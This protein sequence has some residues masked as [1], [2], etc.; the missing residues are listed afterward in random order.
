MTALEI[1]AWLPAAIWVYLLLFRGLFW[2][3]TVRLRSPGDLD[4]WPSVAV[5]VPARNEAEIIGETLP[6]LL[7]QKYPGR[8]EI[9]LV[10]DSS[11]DGTGQVASALTQPG[12]L[13]LHVAGGEERPV[14]W[15]GK[16]WA[17]RQGV[18]AATEEMDPEWFLFTDADIAHPPDSLASLVHAAVIDGRDLVSLMARLRTATL[19]ERLIVPAFVYFFSQLY[20]FRLIARSRSRT[21]GAAG[22]C[23]LLRA[24]ALRRAGGVEAI[25]G[26]VIDDVALGRAVKRS[27]GAT[28]LGYADRVASLRPY[29]RLG[30]LWDMVARS[31]YTQLWYSPL[32]LAGTVV[33]LCVIYLGP[34]AV[35]IAGLATGSGAVSAA[36]AVAWAIL[37]ASYVPM[38]RYYRINP[39]WAL[40][41]PLAA[42]LYGA[43]TVDSARRHYRGAGAAWKGRT[44]SSAGAR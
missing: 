12:G 32:A 24:E 20:P 42:G 39:L 9:F 7:A 36:G 33:G 16:T 23:V 19:W 43:M 3:P 31:A 40:A 34:A 2:L 1:V 38:V 30:D 10:D 29:P 11:D 15:V 5:V 14:G 13:P 8:A 26:A 44:Y 6:T 18:A 41:L 21:A 4:S 22:G 37:T 27:G 25:A 35:T 17:L 28:W